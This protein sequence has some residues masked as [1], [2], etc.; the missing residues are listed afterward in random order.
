MEKETAKKLIDT[1][2]SWISISIDAGTEEMYRK[3]RGQSWKTLWNNIDT[4]IE[5]K[6]DRCKPVLKASMIITNTNIVTLPNLI[7]ELAKRN[8]FELLLIYKMD[9]YLGFDKSNWNDNSGIFDYKKEKNVDSQ[10]EFTYITKAID[11]AHEFNFNLI[12]RG[13]FLGNNYEHNSM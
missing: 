12:A 5:L 9:E 13:N 4:L 10:K 3:I 1:N 8:A 6:G 2:V 11:L 7:E